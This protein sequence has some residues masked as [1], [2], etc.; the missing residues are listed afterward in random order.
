[1][2]TPATELGKKILSQ[3][4]QLSSM[5]KTDGAGSIRRAAEDADYVR[6]GIDRKFVAKWEDGQRASTEPGHFEWWYF[7][8]QLD[9][10]ATLVVGF[11]TK[12][13]TNPGAMLSPLI[14]I[15]LTLPNGRILNKAY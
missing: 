8:A 2:D 6:L 14:T 13:T 7:D 9:D 5:S 12:P 11:Y 4:T 10:G 15:N 3:G 1:M